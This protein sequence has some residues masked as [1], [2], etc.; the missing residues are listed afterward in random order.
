M[1][2]FVGAF[3]TGFVL[4]SSKAYRT[5]LKSSYGIALLA[6]IFF[7]SNCRAHNYAL[8]LSSSAIL[9]FTLLPVIPSTIVN[10]VECIYPLSEDIALGLLYICANTL[11]IA[12]TFIGQVLLTI[13]S[14]GPAP[15]FPYGIWVIATMTAGVLPVL[16]YKGQYLRLEQDD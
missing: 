7:A 16:T 4:D 13:D 14:F 8:L 6:W 9:G 15:L 10:S 3:L 5:V 1:G 12:M 11:A 2:G